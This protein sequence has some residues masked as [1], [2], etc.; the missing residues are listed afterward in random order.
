M[1]AKITVVPAQSSEADADARAT[2]VVI[3][4]NRCAELHRT[5]AHMTSLPDGMPI[6][7]VDN[8]SED[9]SADMVESKFPQVTLLRADQNLGAIVRNKAIATIDTPYVAFCDDDTQWQ[10]GALGRAASWCS[11][12]R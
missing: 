3:T 1:E 6:V 7:V 11:S 2:V 8:A 10:P 4:H 5:L 12:T 9:G